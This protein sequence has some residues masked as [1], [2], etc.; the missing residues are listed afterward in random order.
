MKSL[1]SFFLLATA[2]L[3]A[4]LGP[5]TPGAYTLVQETRIDRTT[6]EYEY[7]ISAT[8]TGTATAINVSAVATSNHPNIT[9]VSGSNTLNFPNINGGQSALSTNTFRF[10]FLRT[11]AFNPSMITWAFNA[12]VAAPTANAG[13]NQNVN[14]GQQVTLNASGSTDPNGLPLTR[15][16]SL[17]LPANC[18]GISLSSTTDVMPTFPANCV[19]N[20]TAQLIVRNSLNVSSAPVS[21]TIS[22]AAVAPTANAGSN[23][24]L[25]LTQVNPTVSLNGSASTS[26]GN[27]PLTYTWSFLNRP[28][29]SVATLSNVNAVQPTFTADRIGLYRLQLIVNN[30]F[31]SSSPST[32]EITTSNLRPTA[33][34]GNS[35]SAT[36]N[37]L[38][39]LNGNQST[40]P[41]SLPLTYTWSLTTRPATSNATLSALNIV[42][43]TFTLDVNGTYIAQLVVCNPFQCSDPATVTISTQLLAPT[44]RP[45]NPQTVNVGATVNLS[46]LTSSDPQGLPL[47]YSWSFNNRPSGSSAAFTSTTSPTPSFTPDRFGDYVVQLTVSNGTLSSPPATVTISTNYV[48]PTANAGTNQNATVNGTVNLSGL[49]SQSFSGYGLTYAWSFNTRPT[50]S[51]AT[52]T[53]P[54]SA[55]PT[56][57]PDLPGLY[58]VQLIVNDTIQNSAP[59]TV[60]ISASF[61]NSITVTGPASILSFEQANG[62][63]TLSNPAGAGGQTVNLSASGTGTATIPASVLVPASNTAANFPITGGTTAGPL[64]IQGAF[65]GFASGSLNTTIANR[66]MTLTTTQPILAIGQSFGGTLTLNNPAP[67]GGATINLSSSNTG[68]FTVSTP[69][70]NIPAGQSNANFTYTATG[71]GQAEINASAPGYISTGLIVTVSG[72]TILLPNN[73]PLGLTQSTVY[74]VG[75]ST[76]A[77]TGGTTINFTTQPGV[78][79]NPSS[80]FI[81]AGQTSPAAS[82][83][84][85]GNALGT[86]TI[87]ATAIGFPP[88]ADSATVTIGVSLNPGT[89]SVNVG[90]TSNV[91]V[92]LSAPAPTGGISLNITGNNAAT[93]T[94]PSPL[95]IT[96]GQTQGTLVVTG[97][98][99]GS[100]TAT[101]SGTNTNSPTLT[102]SVTTPQPVTI[103]GNTNL[104]RNAQE[105]LT[106]NLGQNAPP[107]GLTATLSTTSPN[108]LLTTNPALQGTS[109]ISVTFAGNTQNSPP[110]YVQNVNASSGSA[111]VRFEAQGYATTDRTFNFFPS[112][113]TLS[114][115]TINS[116]ASAPALPLT[117]NFN[118]LS[119]TTLD[120]QQTMRGGYSESLSLTN[121]TP[122]AATVTTPLT[123]TGGQSSQTFSSVLSPTAAGGQ[124]NINITQPAGYTAPTPNPDTVVTVSNLTVSLL[125]ISSGQNVIGRNQQ[126]AHLVRLNGPAA[127]LTPITLTAPAG[128]LLSSNATTAGSSSIIVNIAATQTDSPQFFI[129]NVNQDSGSPSISITSTNPLVAAGSGSVLY[130]RS[131]FYPWNPTSSSSTLNMNLSQPAAPLEVW[132]ARLD[133]SN[134]R[135][136]DMPMR[137]GYSETIT[138]TTLPNGVV[139]LPASVTFN[140]STAASQTFNSSITPTSVNSTAITINQPT[141][142]FA[143]T[144]YPPLTVNVSNNQIVLSLP[145]SIGYDQVACGTLSLNPAAPAGGLSLQVSSPGNVSFST[146]SSVVGQNP[147]PINFT[148]GGSSSTLCVHNIATS[149]GTA[150]VNV[151]VLTAGSNYAATP[152]NVSLWPSGFYPWPPTIALNTLNTNGADLQ[153]WF[154]RINP[155]N[156]AY[157]GDLPLRPGAGPKTITL[158]N[159]NPAAVSLPASVV[160]PDDGTSQVRTYTG[161]IDNVAPAAAGTSN[162]TV[163]QPTGHTAN[164]TYTTSVVTVSA[165]TISINCSNVIGF[166]LQA[167]C[168]FFAAQP[169]PSTLTANLSSNSANL[170]I[171]A[172]RTAVGAQTI[173]PTITAGNSS[174]TFFAQ[175]LASS[176][177]ATITVSIPGYASATANVTLSN[178]G[179]YTWPGATINNG[180]TANVNVYSAVLGAGPGFPRL[181]EQEVRGGTSVTLNIASTNPGIHSAL[182]TVTF[183]TT[184][185]STTG[186]SRSFN[187]TGVAPG[188][189]SISVVQ[190]AGYQQTST[191]SYILTVN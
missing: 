161:I 163:N 113:F 164:I 116:T 155:A 174:L 145:S 20:F 137:G 153:V 7:R 69:T 23:Q 53:N 167:Q 14:L 150:T 148:Q 88:A 3:Q 75:L 94:I 158:N 59:S 187:I 111:S 127:V 109:S 165:P 74:P 105:T 177:S 61:G 189:A 80:V 77:P 40:D 133:G 37:T 169:L 19:G 101:V 160:Y 188:T 66:G 154:A 12:S 125:A 95:V 25:S 43:P 38:V 67:T 152:A 156:N 117:I 102:I 146:S 10:R 84:I 34:P 107:A 72:S 63:V 39:N 128:T 138:F 35:Q 96:A 186:N 118:R 129:Q 144:T 42:N 9:I 56:F 178:S 4:Q 85:T 1:V 21:V 170:L 81:A 104:G 191:Y 131:G 70:L 179:F 86:V 132:F 143:T 168:S 157:A 103:T 45:G 16:W 18:A 182:P 185:V 55:Q 166:N 130:T 6:F 175:A 31:L 97:V 71:I 33:N 126:A 121:S 78:T 76:A 141:G 110:I 50:N 114:Q 47:N 139:T 162:I 119:G 180:G 147:L 91:T 140:S 32:V 135:T 134:A 123:F 99:Q 62:T 27:L 8:N 90:Q 112:A 151:T 108:I 87:N 106:V 172:D 51:N 190:P 13:Q 115:A 92:N 15:Q 41:N 98:A 57:V 60:Q 159:S 17:T 48:V 29:N 49:A 65:T 68:V 173:T 120:G 82:P 26:P 36:I 171:S 89:V 52:L 176:G 136:A 122:A 2:A 22:T 93:A 24:S 79:I 100:T 11:V 46:G 183:S 73:F 83:T 5:F 44:A 184:P 28:T 124:T 54:T 181:A 142:Y 30:G 149:T 58:I 64:T